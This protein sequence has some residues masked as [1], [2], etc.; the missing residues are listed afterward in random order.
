MSA[1]DPHRYVG[2]SGSLAA[3]GYSPGPIDGRYGPRT[4]AA[5]RRFQAARHLE[6]DGIAGPQTLGDLQTPPGRRV[7]PQPRPVPR[8]HEPGRT[9][10][11]AP[12][13]PGPTA[14]PAGADLFRRR[15]IMPAVPVACSSIVW[16]IVAACLL[17]A[18]LAAGLWLRRRAGG[19]GVPTAGELPAP[20]APPQ[21]AREAAADGRDRLPHEDLPDLAAWS[22]AYQKRTA[23][24]LADGGKEDLHMGA[25]AVM[26]LAAFRLGLLLAKK[27]TA[28]PPRMRF[29][30][31]MST[32]IPGPRASWEYCASWRAIM[33]EPRTPFGGRTSAVILRLR[34]IS[35]GCSLRRAIVRRRSRRSGAPLNVA[36]RMPASIWECSCWR[37]ATTPPRR[38]YS[39]MPTSAATRRAACNLGVLLEQRGDLDGAREAYQRADERGHGVGTCNL[40]ALL[41]QQGDLAGPGRR[42]SEPMSAAMHSPRINLGLLLE[43]EG[44][45]ADAKEAYR[46]ADQRGNPDGAR[47]L[48]FLL[49]QEGDHARRATRHSNMPVNRA[50]RRSRKLRTPLGSGSSEAGGVSD[51]HPREGLSYAEAPTPPGVARSAHTGGDC[52]SGWPCP[53]DDA[54]SAE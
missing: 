10:G 25:A 19:A 33:K 11:R 9:A 54:G 27:A 43:D 38:H 6:V 4:E 28:S 7:H 49:E 3:S 26:G 39:G 20:V 32:A 1:G 18:A 24:M 5:V 17:A 44:N 23:E 36:T 50:H 45:L 12:R 40:G 41:A 22:I 46:R 16:F 2:C 14:L 30:A 29:G 35:A 31:R 52:R 37:R 53:I 42:I 51:E 48:G 34:S 8:A 21:N 13:L 47:R 15:R